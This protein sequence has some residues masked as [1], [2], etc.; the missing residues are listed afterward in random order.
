MRGSTCPPAAACACRRRR[1][2]PD[3]SP[4][5]SVRSSGLR[6]TVHMPSPSPRMTPIAAGLLTSAASRL[7]RVCDRVV[8]RHS[9]AREQQRAVQLVLDERAGAEPLRVRRGRLG[10]RVAALLERDGAC[11]DGQHQQRGEPGQQG[12]QAAVRALARRRGSRRRTRA[13]S[14]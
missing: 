6:A 4:A 1:A 11:H 13:R 7:P 14:R 5:A 3:G 12:P 2:L 10:A 9:L 8:E